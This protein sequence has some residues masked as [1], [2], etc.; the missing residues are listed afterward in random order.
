MKIKNDL[1]LKA[2][3]LQETD[4]TPVWVMRQAGRYLP[5]YRKVR[6][7]AGSFMDMAQNPELVCE[8]TLQPLRRYP[9]DAVIIFSDILT[10]P[11][12]MGLGLDFIPGVGPKFAKPITCEKDV[13]DLPN[14][15]VGTDL[16]YVMDGLSLTSKTLDFEVPLLGFAGSPWTLMTYMVE[17]G[18]SKTYSKSKAMIYN[19][20]LV[21]H[22]LL[23]KITDSTIDYLNAQIESGANAVQVFDSWGGVLSPEIY[24]NFSLKYLQQIVEGVKAKNPETPV[25][26]FSKGV[27]KNLSLMADTGANCLGVDWTTDLSYARELTKGKVALQGNMDPSVLFANKEAIRAEVKKV[28]NSYGTGSGHIFNLG[29]G[30]QPEMKPEN[31]GI[32]IDAVREFSQR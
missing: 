23:Q 14:I 27:Q 9:L 4:R 2:L 25:I 3:N 29:H 15:D 17:G 18:G 24:E 13:D 7:Q 19:Q 31:L 20:P 32:M 16:K 28:L 21:A 30:M 26:L 5:E 1:L 11:D 22:K 8:V 6:K 12:A 10:I